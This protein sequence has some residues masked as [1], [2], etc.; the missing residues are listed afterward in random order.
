[1]IENN[2]DLKV[3]LEDTLREINRCGFDDRYKIG[4][5][6]EDIIRNVEERRSVETDGNMKTNLLHTKGFAQ[7]ILNEEYS[8][9]IGVSNRRLSEKRK[10]V[11]LGDVKQGISRYVNPL[12]SAIRIR[13]RDI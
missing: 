4:S 7:S 5:L 11:L 13:S 3:Y 8:S 1:M 12:I 9:L 6:I 2:E 10:S